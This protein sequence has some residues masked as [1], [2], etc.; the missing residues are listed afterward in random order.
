MLILSGIKL[1]QIY[2]LEEQVFLR[3]KE[4]L[5]SSPLD[6]CSTDLDFSFSR[7]RSSYTDEEA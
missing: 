6:N 4:Q 5:L 3:R 1:C 7:P 2:F